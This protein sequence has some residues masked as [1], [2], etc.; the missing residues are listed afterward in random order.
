MKAADERKHE[1]QRKQKTKGKVRARGEEEAEIDI[2]RNEGYRRTGS[3]GNLI[4]RE[5]E[6][7]IEKLEIEHYI[8]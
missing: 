6:K 4:K 3:R 8:R 5:S 7:Q 2:E 1:E